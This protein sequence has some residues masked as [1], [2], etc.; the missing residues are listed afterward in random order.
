MV[1]AEPDHGADGKL[2]HLIGRA[3]PDAAN[4]RE[5]IPVPKRGAKAVPLQKRPQRLVEL[6]VGAALGQPRAQAVEAQQISQHTPERGTHCVAALREHG[7][8]R[9]AAP[10]QSA[11]FACR[12]LHRK[13]HVRRRRGYI[14]LA[15]QRG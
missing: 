10:L 3:A 13:R 12:H 4:H 6:G 14:E 5:K 2:Q 9:G 1:V 8:Q 11:T 15:Q 7:T